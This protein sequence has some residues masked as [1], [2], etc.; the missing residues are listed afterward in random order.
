M[1]VTFE[2]L[3]CVGYITHN[4]GISWADRMNDFEFTIFVVLDLEFNIVMEDS[5]IKK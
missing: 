5:S 4:V 1:E 3:N 2:G